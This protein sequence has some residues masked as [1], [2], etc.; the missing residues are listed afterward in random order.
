MVQQATRRVVRWGSVLDT[1]PAASV[2]PTAM[3]EAIAAMTPPQPVLQVSQFEPSKYYPSLSYNSLFL[4]SSCSLPPSLPLPISYLL[5][6]PFHPPPTLP[7]TLPP[8]PV[9]GSCIDAGYDTCCITGDCAG[10][11]A[12]S[13]CYCDSICLDFNDCCDDFHDICPGKQDV[14]FT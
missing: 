2:M 14:Y 11:P 7:P 10:V 8:S 13:N 4:L 5:L 6:T 1:L 12:D 9:V 3:P